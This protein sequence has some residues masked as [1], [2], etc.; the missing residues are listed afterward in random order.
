[1]DE[2]EKK[3]RERDNKLAVKNCEWLLKNERRISVETAK[4][5]I[6]EKYQSRANS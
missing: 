3:A 6:G 1:M 4:Q 5:A 2:K